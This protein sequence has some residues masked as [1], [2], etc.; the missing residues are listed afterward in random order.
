MPLF[1]APKLVKVFGLK[2][3]IPAGEISEVPFSEVIDLGGFLN[4]EE[5]TQITI[6]R[7]Q[8]GWYLLHCTIKWI[9]P[10]GPVQP[11]PVTEMQRHFYS[12]V[13]KNG[14]VFSDEARQSANRTTVGEGTWHVM[15]AEM[16]FSPGDV[17][18]L[19]INHSFDIS[20]IK[21]YCHLSLRKIAGVKV[22]SRAR[23]DADVTEDEVITG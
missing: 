23:F 17:L 20:G 7:R 21:A 10:S 12:R 3:N 13:T 14:V 18:R 5:T 16:A 9:I 11:D 6:P 15:A 2:S 8:G 1:R 22:G 19:I 4:P